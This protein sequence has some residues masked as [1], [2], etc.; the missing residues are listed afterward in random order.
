MVEF[1]SVVTNEDNLW[2]NIT[3]HV[4]SGSRSGVLPSGMLGRE[5]PWHPDA[6]RF[7]QN[8]YTEGGHVG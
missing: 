3:S 2:C 6:V 1:V 5:E 8:R 7:V 4:L